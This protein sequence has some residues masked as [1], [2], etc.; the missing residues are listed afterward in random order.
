M[1][2]TGMDYAAARA[3]A[4]PGGE[5]DADLLNACLKAIEGGRLRGQARIAET[6]ADA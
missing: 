4:D 3:I 1:I 2:C 5:L 6:E